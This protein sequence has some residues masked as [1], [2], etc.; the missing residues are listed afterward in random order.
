MRLA[1]GYAAA[2][3]FNEGQPGRDGAAAPARSATPQTIPAVGISFA[4]G[5]ALYNRITG[6]TTVI[7]RVFTSTESD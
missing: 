2:I 1:A 7:A 3:I 4:D 6:G 5:E